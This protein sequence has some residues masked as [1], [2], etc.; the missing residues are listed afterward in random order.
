MTDPIEIPA[1]VLA[2]F[3]QIKA[4]ADASVEFLES[5][6]APPTVVWISATD[7]GTLTESVSVTAHPETIHATANISLPAITASF[8]GEVSLP[9]LPP[10]PEVKMA[11]VWLDAIKPAIQAAVAIGALESLL[12]FAERLL[13]IHP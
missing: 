8:S 5:L 3:R 1:E 12:Q 2:V 7:G 9:P 13:D 4:V 11:R 6:Q 10:V